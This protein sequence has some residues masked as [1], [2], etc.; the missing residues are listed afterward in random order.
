MS[1]RAKREYLEEIKDRY[2]Q[3]NK[4]QKKKILDEFCK[5]CNYN[6][7]YA[8]RLL[9][10]RII[11]KKK[12]K[13]VGS[14]RKY[15]KTEIYEFLR[16]TWKAANLPCSKRLKAMIPQW[17]SYYNTKEG[18]ELSIE[19][20]NLILKISPATIDRMLKPIR[21]LNGKRGLSTTKPGTLIKQS[22]PVKTGQWTESRPGYLEADTVAHCGVSM[23]GMF[24]YTLNTVDI[25]TGWTFQRA[26][27]GKGE[28]NVLEA[29]KS[30]ESSL[31]FELLG[32]DS[33]NGG[34][35]IN[36]HLR[37]YLR[38]RKK[39]VAFTRSRPYKKDDNA[40][41]EEKNW[42][43]V[44]QYFG[45]ERFN[46][47][48]VL[49]MMN[50][51]YRNQWNIFTNFFLPSMKLLSKERKG[52]KTIKKYDEAKTPY[53]R[54]MESK[55]ISKEIKNLLTLQHKKYNPYLLEKEISKKISEIIKIA[56][57]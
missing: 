1:K 56:T 55:Y 35:F 22:I 11:K 45:Y 47:P 53:Q 24:V 14:P 8:I 54:I 10:K 7:K 30:I 36:Y 16:T 13:V 42:T 19:T 2:Q 31:P 38:E 37:A 15:N 12:R 49:P 40:H 28:C 34:E 25:A 29:I 48:E 51:L 57:L 32:F 21:K 17:L 33:D 23:A 20:Q 4:R 50:E 26:I 9:S 6:R 39:R 5:V 43:K 41:I 3:A 52:S 44:R 46:N 27:W 18:K